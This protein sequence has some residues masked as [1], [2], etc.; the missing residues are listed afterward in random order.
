MDKWIPYAVPA[1]F[2]FVGGYILSYWNH[3]LTVRREAGNRRRAFRDKIRSIS[4][5]YDEVNWMNFWKT[6][7][8]SVPEVK[9]ACAGIFEDVRFWRKCGFARYRDTYCSFKQSDLELPHPRTP[10]GMPEYMAANSKKREEAK[11]LLRD[12]LER[13]IRYAR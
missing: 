1:I 3:G 4:L 13:I 9:D 8:K 10:A 7:Q 12:T 6:Y 11:A 2:T 5:R